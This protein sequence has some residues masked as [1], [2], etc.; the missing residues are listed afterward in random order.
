VKLTWF[1]GHRTPEKRAQKHKEKAKPD[2]RGLNEEPPKTREHYN[3]SLP[4]SKLAASEMGKSFG[5]VP[6]KPL[7]GTTRTRSFDYS[8]MLPEDVRAQG[9]TLTVKEH[10]NE[11][12]EEHPGQYQA[13]VHNSNIPG[14]GSSGWLGSVLSTRQGDKLNVHDT[15]LSQEHRGKGL[16]R[17]MYEALYHH[18]AKGGVRRIEGGLHTDAAAGVHNSIARKHG[19]HIEGGNGASYEYSLPISDKLEKNDASRGYTYHF[20]KY[21]NKHEETGLDLPEGTMLHE[22]EVRHNG[23]HIG[24]VSGSIEGDTL[25][26]HGADLHSAHHGR[27]VGKQMYNELYKQSAGHG[28]KQIKSYFPSEEALRVHD[29]IARHH[30]LTISGRERGNLS[31]KNP[32][33][34][35]MAKGMPLGLSKGK[36]LQFQRPQPQG[37]ELVHYSPTT[38]L[39][40]LDPS[41]MGTSG[42]RGAQYKRGVPE[43]KSTFYYTLDSH[44]EAEVTQGAR[45]AYSVR[46]EPHHKVYDLAQD[47]E[48]ALAAV[49][50]QNG[51][52]FNE[53]MLHAHLKSKG[54]HGVRWS[55]RDGT[56]VVQMYHPMKVHSELPAQAPTKLAATERD[57]PKRDRE[58]LVKSDSSDFSEAERLSGYNEEMAELLTKGFIR[59]ALVHSAVAASVAA[60][61]AT[62][63]GPLK[64]E[65]ASRRPAGMVREHRDEFAEK[66]LAAIKEVETSGGTNVNHKPIVGGMHDGHAAYGRYGLMPITIKE[67][68]QLD[69]EIAQQHPDL[70]RLKEDKVHDYMKANPELGPKI[71]RSHLNRLRSHF[72]DDPRKIGYAWL[73]GITGT[74]QALRSGKDLSGHWH[75]KK[76]MDALGTPDT[77]SP[78]QSSMVIGANDVET[79]RD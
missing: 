13:Q 69:P 53:D 55:M 41:F 17:A 19:I 27:G 59:D 16:G 18:V 65:S 40:T 9:Y 56:K 51:G 15:E 24:S 34:K 74:K 35:H 38:G 7:K 33:T 21:P 12:T 36:V 25:H 73:N 62:A 3:A 58:V 77:K 46:L 1:Y 79:T 23:K 54:Y 57:A 8:H 30:G 67:T 50:E 48:Q 28:V 39:K 64:D 70:G 5:H 66:M 29:S 10:R 61:P 31:Y 75:V 47:P 11:G 60:A 49:R 26:V 44:P 42:V 20:S 63:Q 43:N 37:E 14:R 32:F 76:V 78:R 68:A 71:A 52:A 2:W 4:K 72:G 22:V 45:S 6:S